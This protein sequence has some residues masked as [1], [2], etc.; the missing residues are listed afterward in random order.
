LEELAIKGFKIINANIL[1]KTGLNLFCFRS[2]QPTILKNGVYY[3]T[4]DIN[5]KKV[6]TEL[7]RLYNLT[8]ISN[9][10][11]TILLLLNSSW[12]G[13]LYKEGAFLVNILGFYIKVRSNTINVLVNKDLLH[14][15]EDFCIHAK[16]VLRNID[17]F[18]KRIQI[19]EL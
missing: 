11:I 4:K 10:Q 1:L 16:I 12:D 7:K 6:R 17:Y 13:V 8:N 15:D 3:F 19:E 5:F 14:I 2:E 9:Y 18:F